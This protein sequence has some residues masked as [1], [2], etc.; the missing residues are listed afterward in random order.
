MSAVII[1]VLFSLARVSTL[2]VGD[3]ILLRWLESTR[4]VKMPEAVVLPVSHIPSFGGHCCPGVLGP[5]PADGDLSSSS[6]GSILPSLFSK[7]R[8]TSGDDSGANGLELECCTVFICVT[9]T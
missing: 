3:E 2:S 9:V 6:F 8:H 1:L 5:V 7:L 4:A